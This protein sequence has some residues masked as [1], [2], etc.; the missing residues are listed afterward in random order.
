[1]AQWAPHPK[2]HEEDVPI[3]QKLVN[4]TPPANLEPPAHHEEFITDAEAYKCLL[5]DS[6]SQGFAV[7]K[8]NGGKV[9]GIIRRTFSCSHHGRATQN[10]RKL[11][12]HVLRDE[13]GKI[14]TDRTR[15]RTNLNARGCK[16]HCS[17]ALR[18]SLIDSEVQR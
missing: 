14:T 2:L 12:P 18:T 8:T 1:M 7:V 10:N 11:A 17:V 5:D 9:G 4:A 15:E 13:E 16:W 6:F 3:I